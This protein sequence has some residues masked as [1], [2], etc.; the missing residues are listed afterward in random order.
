MAAQEEECARLHK[1]NA[2]L[3]VA[4]SK[5]PR[6]VEPRDYECKLCMDAPI[7]S[8][9]LPCGHCMACAHCARAMARCPVC[10]EPVSGLTQVYMG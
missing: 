1:E 3:R 9:F 4:L 8:V 6:I 7:E 5:T 10:M 2:A